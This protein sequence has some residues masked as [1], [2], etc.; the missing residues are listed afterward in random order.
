M[1]GDH[2]IFRRILWRYRTSGLAYSGGNSEKVEKIADY[3]II[4]GFIDGSESGFGDFSG[5][6]ILALEFKLIF[7]PVKQIFLILKNFLFL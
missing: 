3:P 7:L 5:F 2:G 1:R 6:G 4:P